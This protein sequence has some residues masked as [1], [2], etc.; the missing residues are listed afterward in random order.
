M[1]KTYE[2]LIYDGI[3]SGYTFFTTAEGIE[4]LREIS[5]P[6]IGQPTAALLPPGS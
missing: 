3:C 2:R 6:H 1:L 5:H 4:C